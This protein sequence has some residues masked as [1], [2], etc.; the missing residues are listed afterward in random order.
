MLVATGIKMQSSDTEPIVR[1]RDLKKNSVN[2]V[3]ENVDLSF[4]HFQLLW[5]AR[6]N[7]PSRDSR[8]ANSFRRVMIADIP[9]VG[10][11]EHAFYCG[12]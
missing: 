10:E 1:I 5:C 2:F 9:T 12:L 4:V 6:I 3:L 7:S 8:F 11:R